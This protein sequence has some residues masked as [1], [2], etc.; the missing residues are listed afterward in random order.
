MKVTTLSMNVKTKDDAKVFQN[1]FLLVDGWHQPIEAKVLKKQFK[2]YTVLVCY[3][4]FIAKKKVENSN[5]T[6]WQD[7]PWSYLDVSV[8][9]E[10]VLRGEIHYKGEGGDIYGF[11]LS[12]IF[13]DI[14]KA[15]ELIE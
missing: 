10:D 14:K 8:V 12:S 7:Y 4:D 9:R 1:L 3:H 2:D 11:D 5:P 6:Q 13:A 15:E